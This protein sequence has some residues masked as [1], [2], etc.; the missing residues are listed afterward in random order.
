MSGLEKSADFKAV[1]EIVELEVVFR[2]VDGSGS[3]LWLDLE[4]V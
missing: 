4:R 1:T 2:D 3:I